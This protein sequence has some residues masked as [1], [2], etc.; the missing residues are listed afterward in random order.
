MCSSGFTPVSSSDVTY[1]ARRRHQSSPAA[2]SM[3]IKTLTQNVNYYFSIWVCA[4]ADRE[5]NNHARLIFTASVE[6]H[7]VKNEHKSEKK[8]SRRHFDVC[9]FLVYFRSAS[10]PCPLGASEMLQA[11]SPLKA[12]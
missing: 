9:N 7:Q 11:L 12:K 1:A 10:C 3:P 6:K 4:N 2:A 5:S 8:Q